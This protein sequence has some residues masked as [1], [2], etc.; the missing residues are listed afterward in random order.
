MK[1]SPFESPF[2]W[3]NDFAR[4]QAE[5]A[6]RQQIY[7][8]TT[9]IYSD[10]PLEFPDIGIKYGDTVLNPDRQLTGKFQDY[11]T[12]VG[13]DFYTGGFRKECEEIDNVED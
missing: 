4:Q 2:E 13:D 8:P 1:K 6:R 5:Y 12:D 3:A 10:Y 9:D 7:S 11:L